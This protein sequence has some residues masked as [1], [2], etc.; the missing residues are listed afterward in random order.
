M[1]YKIIKYL[2][3]SF[4]L[5]TNLNIQE[6]TLDYNKYKDILEYLPLSFNNNLDKSVLEKNELLLAIKSFCEKQN[7][8][9]FIISLSGGVDSMVLISI[10]RNLGYRTVGVHI[11]YNNREETKKEQEFLEEWCKNNSIVL[12][13]H[14]IPDIKRQNSKRSTY[15]L[16][17]KNIR[18]NFYHQVL[19]SESYINNFNVDYKN[20]ILIGHHK[21]DIVENI[22]ANVCRGRYILDLAVIKETN[23]I[24]NITIARPMIEFY[25][26]SIYEFAI[27]NNVPYF[28]DTTPEW[29]IRGK[30]RNNIYPLLEDAFSN[31]IKNN[32]LGLSNQ[33]YEWNK[34]IMID[35]IEPFLN[36]IEV[37]SN[38]CKFNVQKHVDKPLCFWNLIFMKIFYKYNLNCP[39]RKGIQTFIDHIN[40]IGYVSISKNCKC[41]IKNYD[42]E[43]KFNLDNEINYIE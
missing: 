15:E 39:S 6:P 3:N 1:I 9:T 32:L 26:K 34:L 19:Q 21:D 29:S 38:Y 8:S 7:T 30:Y 36:E 16:E 42:V 14:S 40:R 4:I 18:F 11:N 2:Y 31:N 5:Y 20:M 43:I 23:E 24:N 25:K 17:T 10:I 33:S 13:T 35:I 12:Y 37:W 28:K 22:F 27:D 41:Y